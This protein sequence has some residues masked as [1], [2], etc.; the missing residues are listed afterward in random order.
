M[1]YTER[2]YR[3]S[4]GNRF[5]SFTVKEGETDLW[6]GIDKNS[7]SGEFIRIANKEVKEVRNEIMRYASKHPG[8]YTSLLPFPY[9]FEAPETVK[10]MIS[11]GKEANVGPMAAVAGTIAEKI[12]HLLVKAGANEVIVENGGDI[13]VKIEKPIV[14]EIFSGKSPLNGKVFLRVEKD[15]TPCGICTSSATV[16]LSLSFGTADAVT[17]ISKNVALADSL[18]TK[19]CNEVKSEKDVG[20]VLKKIPDGIEGIV[21]ITNDVLGSSGKN[22]HFVGGYR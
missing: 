14:V 16:G 10:C 9:D 13:F 22:V 8:F 18:A 11:A 4:M 3:K 15:E 12:G 19:Y 5:S 1:L 6:V 7:F 2:F 21:I 20:K 17:V